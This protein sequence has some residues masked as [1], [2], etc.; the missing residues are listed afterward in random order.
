MGGQGGKGMG[1]SWSPQNV[2]SDGKGNSS[3]PN[4][5]QALHMEWNGEEVD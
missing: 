3:G 4:C 1:F 2:I 5:L